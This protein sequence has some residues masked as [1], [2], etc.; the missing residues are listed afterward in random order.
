MNQHESTPHSA[1]PDRQGTSGKPPR[2]EQI[3]KDLRKLKSQVEE[4]SKEIDVLKTVYAD[5]LVN[6]PKSI[7]PQAAMESNGNK[8]DPDPERLKELEDTQAAIKRDLKELQEQV[9]HQAEG[10]GNKHDPDPELKERRGLWA[11]IV[12]LFNKLFGR[13]RS[14]AKGNGNKHD[15]DPERL[16]RLEDTQAAIKRDLKELQEQVKYQAESNGNKHDP[17]PD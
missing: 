17:D 14:R 8:H 12:R 16:K 6:L 7:E 4:I 15:P 5:E 10:N 11:A 9:K 13:S 1:S 3:E 2:L